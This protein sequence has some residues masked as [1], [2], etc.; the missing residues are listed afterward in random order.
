MRDTLWP[1]IVHRDGDDHW[2]H[3]DTLTTPRETGTW[4]NPLERDREALAM[5]RDLFESECASCHGDQGRGD[6]PGAGVSDPRPYDFTRAEFTGMGVPP[7]P[8]LL[9]AILARGIDG[10]TMRA[11]P[12]LSGYERLALIAYIQT[13]P[14]T[15]ATAQRAAWADT[16]RSRRG[17]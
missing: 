11:F 14:G 4:C 6:G 7:G 3:L 5:G 16:L 13:L 12:E 8:A 1:L 10:T 15:T 17:Y 9:Y 2:A